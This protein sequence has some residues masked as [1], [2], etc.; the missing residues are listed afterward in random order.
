MGN[1][2]DDWGNKAAKSENELLINYA[3]TPRGW[4]SAISEEPLYMHFMVQV[5]GSGS[6]ACII[7]APDPEGEAGAPFRCPDSVISDLIVGPGS[8]ISEPIRH[9]L[10][11]VVCEYIMYCT[12]YY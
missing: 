6:P 8:G 12:G 4:Q 10:V 3:L 1:V 9:N 2:L 11:L 5:V 7:T